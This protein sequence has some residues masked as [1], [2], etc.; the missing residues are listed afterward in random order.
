MDDVDDLPLQWHQLTQLDESK[1][2]REIVVNTRQQSRVRPVR[3][4]D[5]AWRRWQANTR[6]D[7]GEPQLREMSSIRSG[8][9]ED[10]MTTT[11][12]WYGCSSHDASSS[13]ITTTGWNGAAVNG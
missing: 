8:T 9:A 13:A 3:R 1:A 6:R 5:D 2:E 4:P 7:V 12:D 10:H 11:L